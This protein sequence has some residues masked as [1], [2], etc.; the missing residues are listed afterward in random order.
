MKD[1]EGTGKES[2]SDEFLH[3]SSF[4]LH[5]FSVMASIRV[6]S[7]G[8]MTTV[9]DLGR[10]GC[11]RLGISPAGAMDAY[12]LRLANLLVGN[13]AGEACLEIT[14]LGP[15]LEFT[16]PTVF[17]LTGADLSPALNG[18]AVE[19]W[20]TVPVERGDVLS[21]GGARSGCRTYLAC[22]GG[23]LIPPVMGSKSTLTR[24]TL[25][26]LDGGPLKAGD[27]LPIAPSPERRPSGRA[28]SAYRRQFGQSVIARMILGPQDECFTRE[29]FR[30]L[31]GSSFTVNRNSDRMGLRLS[32]PRLRHRG[33]ADI[34]SDAV[35]AGAVQVPGDGNPIILTADRPTTGGYPKI[36]VVITPD[37]D[38]LGQAKPGDEVRFTAVSLEQAHQVYRQYMEGFDRFAAVSPGNQ[39]D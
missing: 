19:M 28:P 11:Q 33:S 24:A 26:G 2:G 38:L 20:A 23:F 1:E 21:F 22:R 17:A 30:L 36:G 34:V 3:P 31:L 12:S 25:G 15:R 35:V 18:L 37:V 5:P 32:G 6:L 39:P 13:A 14:L 16:A 29:T 10:F 9:Q 4:I 27:E 8:M 7:P